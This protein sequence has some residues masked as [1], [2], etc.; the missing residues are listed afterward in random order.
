M[1]KVKL[2]QRL[3]WFKVDGLFKKVR[4]HCALSECMDMQ[5]GGS[6]N[7]AK[8]HLWFGTRVG[9]SVVRQYDEVYERHVW[10]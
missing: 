3:N 10:K 4:A 2:V 8:C 9:A 6:S 5:I 7:V 1:S